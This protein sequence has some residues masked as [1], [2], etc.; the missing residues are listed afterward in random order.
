MPS[1]KVMPK[2]SGKL[3]LSKLGDIPSYNFENSLA[4]H[5]ALYNVN[6]DKAKLDFL[7]YPSLSH[8]KKLFVL[9]SGDIQREKNTPPV[10]QRWSW[11]PFFPGNCIYIADPTLNLSDS[12]SLGWYCGD[13]QYDP[14]QYIGKLVEKVCDVKNIS[15]D[16]VVSYGSSGGGFA[17]LRLIRDFPFTQAVA[18]NP[19]TEIKRYHRGKVK[20]YLSECFQ[21]LSEEVVFDSYK[22]RL[23]LVECCN[24]FDG[25]KIIYAQNTQDV[26]H[27]DNHARPFMEKLRSSIKCEVVD[28]HFSS[29]GGHAKAENQDVFEKIILEVDGK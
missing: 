24:G 15:Y 2:N 5:P 18:I 10:F 3:G 22:E 16:N 29:E 6:Y 25:K 14:L 9:F 19:Q 26:F 13:K 11:A 23:N 21:G 8:S 20:H 17:A 1:S 7:W 4:S 27:L 12:L 28:L